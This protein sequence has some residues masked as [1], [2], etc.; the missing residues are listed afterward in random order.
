MAQTLYIYRDNTPTLSFA[1]KNPDGTPANLTG[2]QSIVFT[3]RL[4][5]AGPVMFSHAGAVQSPATSGIFT[6]T[7]IESDTKL[8]TTTTMFYC[9]ALITDGS[10]N[11][12]TVGSNTLIVSP[13]ITRGP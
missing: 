8:L 3:A 4:D 9:D 10:G 13:N 6:V 7:L 2:V 5:P 12:D 1:V 11:L